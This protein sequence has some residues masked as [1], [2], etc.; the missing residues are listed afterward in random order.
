MTKRQKI[1]NSGVN[2]LS[3]DERRVNDSELSGFQI[4][5]SPKSKINYYLFYRLDG[6]Q[7]NYN[8]CVFTTYK[9]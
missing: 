8:N 1:T 9:C 6:K 2:G 3:V 7:V 4:R 5:I